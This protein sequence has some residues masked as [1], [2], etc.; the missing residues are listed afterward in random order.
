MGDYA[1]MVKA[2]TARE[3]GYVD[4]ELEE[5]DRTSGQLV[6]VVLDVLLIHFP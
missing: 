4:T 1:F 6:E 5:A 2:M 3:S